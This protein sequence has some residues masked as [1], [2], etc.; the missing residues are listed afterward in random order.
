MSNYFE[1]MD[2]G[3]VWEGDISSCPMCDSEYLIALETCALCGGPV[4]EDGTHFC[5]TCGEAIDRAF[6]D[7]FEKIDW[8]DKEYADVV[9]LMFDR[10]EERDFYG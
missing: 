1:C 3:R 4:R 7:A 2:C 6:E 8:H 5:K 10:A 9:R